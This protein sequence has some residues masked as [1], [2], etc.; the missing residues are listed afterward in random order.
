[1]IFRVV[2]LNRLIRFVN[3]KLCLTSIN[4][5]SHWQEI[6][7]WR[8]VD[9]NN[10]VGF[11]IIIIRKICEISEYSKPYQKDFVTLSHKTYLQFFEKWLRDRFDSCISFSESWLG[12]MLAAIEWHEA[13][14]RFACASF[15]TWSAHDSPPFQ[16]LHCCL[17]LF[18]GG[19]F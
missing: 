7:M 14:S 6:I 12:K 1:M 13:T 11:Q 2:F 18:K 8:L 3:K 15:I 16:F 10:D 5:K 4:N 9:I 19:I 17:F